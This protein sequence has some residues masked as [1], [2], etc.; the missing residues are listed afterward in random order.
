MS[1]ENETPCAMGDLG[2]ILREQAKVISSLG[3]IMV[4]GMRGD[5]VGISLS[6]WG[7]SLVDKSCLN[8]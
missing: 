4:G 8:T 3:E 1:E 6:S 5:N 7:N 2:I